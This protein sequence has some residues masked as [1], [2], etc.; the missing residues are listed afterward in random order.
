MPYTVKHLC[1]RFNLSR[2]TLLYYD[3]IGLLKPSGRTA[4]NY[5]IFTDDDVKRLEQICIYREVGLPLEEIKSI[6]DAPGRKAAEI[7]EKR[8]DELNR[9]IRDRRRQQR[10]IIG[11]LQN[12]QLL[13]RIDQIDRDGFVK[14]LKQA[15][16]D[17]LGMI[18][19]HNELERLSPDGHQKFLES[20]GVEGEEIKKIRGSARSCLSEPEH[21]KCF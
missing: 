20:L 16:F 11:L 13:S 10:V 1:D 5:R 18:A 12:E 4:G 8:L 2:S 3:S 19:L 15:G 21:V 14:I 17:E 6:L 9:E 7:L